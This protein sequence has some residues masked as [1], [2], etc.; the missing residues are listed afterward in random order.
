MTDRGEDWRLTF[1]TVCVVRHLVLLQTVSQLVSQ[2]PGRQRGELL[3]ALVGLLQD[4]VVHPAVVEAGGVGDGGGPGP[5]GG[6]HRIVEVM[7]LT[8][9]QVVV[10]GRAV[11]DIR[12]LALQAVEPLPVVDRHGD[13]EAEQ[14]DGEDDAEGRAGAVL[15][16]RGLEGGGGGQRVLLPGGRGAVG[17]WSINITLVTL[18]VFCRLR[19]C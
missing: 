2:P 10:T 4:G 8:G 18:I 15:L 14:E 3:P 6:V 17:T 7:R 12:H 11:V 9:T 13:G 16:T 1:L 5:A 19:T